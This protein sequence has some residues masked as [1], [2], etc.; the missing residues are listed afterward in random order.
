MNIAYRTTQK[1]VSGFFCLSYSFFFFFSSLIKSFFFC[2]KKN[3]SKK[4][5]KRLN[6]LRGSFF[7]LSLLS[8]VLFCFCFCFLKFEYCKTY[9]S[10]CFESSQIKTKDNEIYLNLN[11]DMNKIHKY[12]TWRRYCLV[13]QASNYWC[14]NGCTHSNEHKRKKCV[15]CGTTKN[16]YRGEDGGKC[17]IIKTIDSFNLARGYFRKN[18]KYIRL[19][20]VSSIYG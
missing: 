17:P 10:F 13:V 6:G 20:G 18:C 7:I 14:C 5:L 15:Q 12:L 8:Y 1:W 2:E 4:V 19:A 3:V 9:D 16:S 11:H